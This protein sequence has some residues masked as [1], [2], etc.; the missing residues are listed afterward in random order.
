MVQLANWK[1]SKQEHFASV[2]NAKYAA[3]VSA[4]KSPNQNM[5]VMIPNS[6]IQQIAAVY[7]YKI[8][9][10]TNQ[11]PNRGAR[12]LE[13]MCLTEKVVFKQLGFFQKTLGF[14]LFSVTWQVTEIIAFVSVLVYYVLN[15]H[16][17]NY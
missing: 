5:T 4:I 17:L 1:D 14:F 13:E 15:A 2:W 11:L 9:I 7:P 3:L 16:Q 10:S 8:I 12:C 6:P